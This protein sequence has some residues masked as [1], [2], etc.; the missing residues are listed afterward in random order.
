MLWYVKSN[1]K[2]H[3]NHLCSPGSIDDHNIID[4]YAVKATFK[5]TI[6]FNT[7]RHK[8]GQILPETEHAKMNMEN[9]HG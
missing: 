2:L 9:E 3:L 6:A 7:D 1:S 5:L 4:S 8:N